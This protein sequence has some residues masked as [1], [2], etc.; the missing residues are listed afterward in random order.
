[1]RSIPLS[2]RSAFTLIELLVVIAIIAILIG[3][4]LPAVQKVREAANRTRCV[5]NLKQCALGMHTCH[6]A[7]GAF[8]SGGWGWQWLGDSDRGSG[9]SQP[10]GWVFSIMPYI[11]QGNLY[12]QAAGLTGTA[13]LNAQAALSTV[14]LAIMNCPSRRPTMQLP[15]SAS[16][17]YNNATNP[18]LLSGRTD[19]AALGGSLASSSEY[20]GGPA[21]LADGDNT[22]SSGYFQENPSA[23]DPT[24]F[25][26]IFY[27]RSQ[28]H[29]VNIIAGTSNVIMIGEKFVCKD[30]YTTGTDAGDNECMYVGMDND[31]IRSTDAPPIEDQLSTVTSID[32]PA[33]HT[34]RFG[35]AHVR[36]FNAAFADGS[37]RN[38]S[39]LVDPSAF[40]AAG[41]IHNTASEVSLD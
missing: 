36:G 35:S 28:T 2:R 17:V 41:N 29:I 24:I 30:L 26:G 19:Y 20:G 25:T 14:P 22:T 16:F 1:M 39:Y 31:I 8:P 6:D 38:I 40:Q 33:S 21:S 34:T 10:G 11:E 9:P 4:L 18:V 3:L 12:S 15:I 7:N 13:K 23:T 37:V 27:A 5:N 32:T